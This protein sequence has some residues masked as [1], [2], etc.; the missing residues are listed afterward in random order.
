MPDSG[1]HPS[2]ATGGLGL[3]FVRPLPQGLPLPAEPRPVVPRAAY[4][5]LVSQL[6]P[7]KAKEDS[8][9][10]PPVT[11]LSLGHFVIEERIGRGGMGAVFRAIDQRL[12]RVVALKVLA[13]DHSSDPDSVVRFQNEG[14]SAARLDH[15]NIARVY[16]I[17]EEHG[18]H[19]I[20]FE[21]VTGTNVRN[22]IAQRGRLNPS[23][24][25]SFTLQ[26]AEALRNT[27]AANVVHRDIKPSN[28][29]ITPTGRAK[30]V[31]LGLARQINPEISRDLTI[32]GTALGTFDYIAPE[33]AMDARNVDV[34]SDIY[35]LGCTLYHMLTGEPP[36][37]TGT[38][39]E[40][41]MNHHRSTAPDPA[42]KNLRVSPQLS[43]VVQRM[44]ASNPDERY[45]SA[46]SLI[47]DLL[48]IANALGLEPAAPE[49]MIWRAPLA[50]RK[51]PWWEGTRTWM[52]VGAL[53]LVL[54]FG[55]DQ[56][57]L[58]Q[59]RHSAA[60]DVSPGESIPLPAGPVA[61]P[62]IVLPVP[63]PPQ[64]ASTPNPSVP[65][66]PA[67]SSASPEV[68]LPQGLI[69]LQES[70]KQ[71]LDSAT[72]PPSTVPVPTIDPLPQPVRS[73]LGAPPVAVETQTP[74]APP[75][76]TDQIMILQPGPEEN[77]AMPTLAAACLAAVDNAVIEIRSNGTLTVTETLQVLNKRL[78]IRPAPGYRPVLRFDL[79]GTN[80]S[81]S[82]SRVVEMLRVE[83]GV[84]ELYDL[85]LEMVVTPDSTSE[86]ALLS[87]ESQSMLTARGVSF[88][89][90]NPQMLPAMLVH[91]PMS[92]DA[93]I[94][95]LLSD[96]MNARQTSVELNGCLCRGQMDFACQRDVQSAN[97]RLDNVGLAL[98]WS[99]LRIDGSEST[100]NDYVEAGSQEAI[101]LALSH[102]TAVLGRGVMQATSGEHG[103][104]PELQLAI[105]DSVIRVD[106]KEYPLVSISGHQGYESLLDRLLV[107]N[108]R[109]PS[110]FQLA[111]PLCVITSTSSRFLDVHRLTADQF[112]THPHNL[113]DVN[114]LE[115][116]ME[117]DWTALHTIQP[118]D[119][120]LRQDESS[121]FINPAENASGDRQ[122]AGVDWMFPRLPV[123]FPQPARPS[124]PRTSSAGY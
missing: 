108:H 30:L 33:Q 18:L 16:Y 13:P 105:S 55:I 6:F 19:F 3:T 49:S 64:V 65:A 15:D 101:H 2:G 75:A 51:S 109:D 35:S 44:M 86:W 80:Q 50:S 106:Q 60:P 119:L 113:V 42:Q 70:L 10:I 77:Q 27:S 117:M 83:R 72:P 120:H 1:S 124:S 115:L 97:Y 85:D 73:S 110:F 81:G 23:D 5:D 78:R 116:P 22:F 36:Y 98:A 112:G 93:E 47:S 14:R 123:K 20:A 17:G 9:S 29:I 7:P 46:E 8:A 61:A 89:M 90:V 62:E 54:V 38:M 32:A 53:L 122:N 66:D 102:V 99:L 25:V 100:E 39:F 71:L 41:V 67:P 74:L 92:P 58:D 121:D 94:G 114:L 21:F 52:T 79:T 34:R 104:L 82:F 95:A 26:I 59:P 57:H 11:G 63:D 91:V 87:L 37:P 31:D 68:P 12:D 45:Q 96:R 69:A 40:K 24:A 48:P 43:R 56:L 4:H 118:S 88:T 103:T 84:I 107:A 111:G 28:I 76:P